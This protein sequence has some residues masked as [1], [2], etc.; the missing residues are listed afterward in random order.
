MTEELYKQYADLD[1]AIKQL[2]FKKIDMRAKILETLV[3]TNQEKVETSVGSFTVAKKI[4][5]TYSDT[6]KQLEEKLKIK[7][8]NEQTKGVAQASESNYLLY[9]APKDN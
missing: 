7:Q 2:E 8:L 6:L 5:W 1:A 4:K 9:H 3:S